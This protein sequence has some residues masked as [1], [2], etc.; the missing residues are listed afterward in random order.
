MKSASTLFTELGYKLQKISIFN[1]IPGMFHC[2]PLHIFISF[3][4]LQYFLCKNLCF[5]F[6]RFFDLSGAPLIAKKC[7]VLSRGNET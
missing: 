4:M 2:Q 6:I 1:L 7:V 5:M 3:L